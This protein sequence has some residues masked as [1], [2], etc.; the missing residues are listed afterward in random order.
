MWTIQ[1]LSQCHLCTE[2]LSSAGPA[3]YF[4][5]VIFKQI[6]GLLHQ[7]FRKRKG[8][9][10]AIDCLLNVKMILDGYIFARK[11]Y[12]PFQVG[13]GSKCVGF[14]NQKF[15]LEPYNALSFVCIPACFGCAYVMSA[16]RDAMWTFLWFNDRF[17]LR[18]MH[19]A[20]TYSVEFTYH[21]TKANWLGEHD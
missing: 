7:T 12:T 5:I 17:S 9:F 11:E 15:I 3:T 18:H 21:S 8:W 20:W 16:W 14:L 10:L 2:V 4:N 6:D 1:K 13:R 19:A